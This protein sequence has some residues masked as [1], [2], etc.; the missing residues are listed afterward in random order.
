MTS[1]AVSSSSTPTTVVLK[2]GAAIAYA[3][4]GYAAGVALLFVEPWWKNALGVVL[5]AHALLVGAVLIHEFI[6]GSIFKS[7]ELNAF[8]GRV[9]MHI[10][11]A[12]YATWQQI[13][14][15]HMN[16]H[17]HV[18]DFIPFDYGTYIATMAPPVRSVIKALEW[19]YIPGFEFLIRF[20]VITSPFTNPKKH[21]LR[22]RT[23]MIV[24]YRLGLMLVVAFVSLKALLLYGLAYFLFVCLMRLVE[25]FHHTFEYTVQGDPIVKRDRTYEQINTF[26]NVVSVRY[27]W[28]NLLY[29]NFGY[30]NAHH[31]N[32][33]C[34]WHELP[35]HHQRVFDESAGRYGATAGN[36]LSFWESLATYHRFRVARIV[37]DQGEVFDEAGNF[38]LDA[39]TGG[40][41]ASFL[42]PP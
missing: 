5:T 4:V 11:G 16:H 36:L 23:S 6:H 37:G 30:H 2:N 15:H 35:Q 22:W 17:V 13:H 1:Q 19:A 21:H 41:G 24:A 27:P 14:D 42:T 9:M 10:N 34:P 32:M 25:T 28:L 29:L 38:S 18:T 26:S 20:H 3:T 7:R 40:V 31:D 12:C 8:W 33:R 39:F